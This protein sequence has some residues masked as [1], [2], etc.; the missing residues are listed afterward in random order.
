MQRVT[1]GGAR[2]R[3]KSR[4]AA[5][6]VMVRFGDLPGAGPRVP[7]GKWGELKPGTHQVTQLL[8]HLTLFNPVRHPPAQNT[9]K[10]VQT[11]P[12]K[13]LGTCGLQHHDG[14]VYWHI[15]GYG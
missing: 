10:V 7:K 3:S 14:S 4:Q 15:F 13:M 6:L 8:K 2:R 11:L 9:T 1:G 12:D 5:L